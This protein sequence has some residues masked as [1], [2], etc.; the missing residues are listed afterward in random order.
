MWRLTPATAKELCGRIRRVLDHRMVNAHP[1]DDRANPAD[2]KRIERAIGK[3]FEAHERPRASLP[4][5]QVPAFLARLAER[6][7]ASARVLEMIILTGCRAQEIAGARWC[8]IDWKTRTLTIPAERMKTQDDEHGEAHVVP[9]SRAMIRVLRQAIPPGV[10]PAPG[11]LIFPNRKDQ[12]FDNREILHHVKACAEGV[13]A[14]THGFRATITG[15]GTATTHRARPAFDRDLMDVVKAHKLG[16][17]VS[18]AYLR[19]RWV[20]RRRVVMR[21]WSRF[22]YPPQSAVILPLR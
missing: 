9:L 17:Q 16:D 7:Q 5:E 8:E 4:Y 15:W 6:P 18:Q 22:C 19:D 12:P 21:E 3:R 20:D 2:F 13:Q 10:Q 1:D 11:A 14:T